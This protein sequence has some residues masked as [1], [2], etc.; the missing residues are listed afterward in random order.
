MIRTRNMATLIF[1]MFAAH[2]IH[3]QDLSSYR[4]FQ[5]GT[6]LSAIAKQAGLEPSA[7]KVIHER[8]ALIQE[9]EL[10]AQSLFLSSGSSP[11]GDSVES[12]LFSFYNGQTCPGSW[13]SMI[14]KKRKGLTEEDMIEAY[15]G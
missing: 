5:L 13:S 6:S 14:L 3:A 8:P 1:V 9:L 7:A 4:E 2:F 10:A 11:K 15:F 12:I